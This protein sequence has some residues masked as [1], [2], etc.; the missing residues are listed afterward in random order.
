M[1]IRFQDADDVIG[2]APSAAD[3]AL[4]TQLT[5][6]LVNATPRTVHH[7]HEQVRMCI[8][9]LQLQLARAPATVAL[10]SL[11]AQLYGMLKATCCFLHTRTHTSE[12]S[13]C[14]K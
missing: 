3:S 13:Q 1:Q 6:E 5:A 4:H 7:V 8:A 10:E 14:L 12:R 2:P 11:S 9:R